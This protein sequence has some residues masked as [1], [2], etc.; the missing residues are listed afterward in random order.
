MTATRSDISH[1]LDELYAEGSPYTHMI[2]GCD[3]F[4]YEDYPVYITKNEDV[5]AKVTEMLEGQMT[6]VHEVYDRSLE[7]EAQLNESSAWHLG[8]DTT[9]R[10]TFST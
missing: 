10:G 6:G 5:R 1:W 2:V 4:D 7:K 9:P 8:D 3:Q